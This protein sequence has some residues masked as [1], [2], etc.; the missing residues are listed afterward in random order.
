MSGWAW[1]IIVAV[2]FAGGELLTGGLFLAPF[3]VGAVG[4]LAAA[5][6]GAGVAIQVVLFLAASA[7]AFGVL[8]PV[9]RSH[10]R[11]PPSVRTG[12]AALVGRS[13]V[14]LERVGAHEGSVRL[15]GEVWTA[16][17]YLADEVLEPGAEVQVVEIRGATALVSQ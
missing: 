14:V 2:G 15:D 10:V 16:R 7:A 6:L 17:A 11:L 5:G 8:R 3:A 12:T 9:A 4:G 13:A 1:W